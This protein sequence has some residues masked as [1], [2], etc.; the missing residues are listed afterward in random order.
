MG[1][2][3][4]GSG[5]QADLHNPTLYMG[6]GGL[7][8]GRR[9]GG[10]GDCVK[11]EETMSGVRGQGELTQRSAVLG[12]MRAGAGCCLAVNCVLRRWGQA[13]L[14]RAT[15]AGDWWVAR[16]FTCELFLCALCGPHR[17]LMR[18]ASDAYEAARGTLGAQDIIRYAQ[19]GA[20]RARSARARDMLRNAAGSTCHTAAGSLQNPWPLGERAY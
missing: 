9:L 11:R 20:R 6:T 1:G 5:A 15:A 13:R 10:N 8:G 7:Y 2:Q 19:V 3:G 18:F 14:L 12:W 16:S 17:T 4:A